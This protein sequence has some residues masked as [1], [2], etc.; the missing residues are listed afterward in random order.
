MLH[1]SSDG[2]VDLINSTPLTVAGVGSIS[3]GALRRLSEVNVPLTLKQRG[4]TSR[5][6][7]EKDLKLR[8]K[9]LEVHLDA[10][11]RRAVAIKIVK[12]SASNKLALLRYFLPEDRMRELELSFLD[13]LGGLSASLDDMQIMSSEAKVSKLYYEELR[14]VL[15]SEYGFASRT[16]RPPKDPLSA[17][18]SYGNM[19]LYRV[20][21]GLLEAHGLDPR[22][23]FLHKPFRRRPSLALDLAEEFRQPVIEAAV[24]PAFTSRSMSLK[25]DFIKNGEA[26]YLNRRGRAK[27][28]KLLTH[29]LELRVARNIT[30][31]Q[32]IHAQVHKLIDFYLIGTSYEPYCV[33]ERVA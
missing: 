2:V 19:H 9:Q 5:L 7:V 30:L 4:V 33:Q 26:V 20:C 16:R 8:E 23:G 25:A 29:R 13:V 17:C 28:I 21:E 15:P 22:L 12:A 6:Y 3:V 31:R 11:L 32:S 10:Q 27:L 14:N 24:V 18:L 1:R